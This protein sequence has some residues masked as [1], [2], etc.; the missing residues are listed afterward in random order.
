MNSG[1]QG[2]YG[3]KFLIFKLNDL[4]QLVVQ[5][6]FIQKFIKPEAAN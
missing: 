5:D 4:L 6:V 2:V 3:Q 1:Q